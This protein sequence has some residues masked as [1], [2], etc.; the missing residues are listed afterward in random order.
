MNDYSDGLLPQN[1]TH[2]KII[3]I[4]MDAFYAAVEIRDHP[5]LKNKAVVIGQDPRNNNGHGVVAT[6]NYVARQF[7]VHSAMASAKAL[8]LVPQEKLKFLN[9]DFAKYRQVSLAIHQMMAELTDT[10]QSIAL[11]EAYLDVSQNKLG[12]TSS[13]QLAIDL[14]ARIR[15]EV[16]LN[17]SF[18]A[19]YNKFLAKMGSE[20]S[21]PLGRTVILPSEAKSFLARQKIANFHGIGPKTQARLAE[22]GVYTGGDLQK[23][24]VRQLIDQFNRAGYMMAAHANGIDLSRVVPDNERNRK[25]IGIERTYE[26]CV[27][28]EQVALTNIRNYALDLS[29]KLQN[30]EF[31]ANTIVL[32]IRNNDFETVTKRHKLDHATN[33]STEIYEAA[34]AL[35]DPLATQFLNVGI[36]L[37]GVTA[38]DFSEA[39]FENITLD[40]FTD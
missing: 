22:L 23:M 28:D 14:Q 31:F 16:G 37:L 39:D 9:P 13:V 36:R 38:T 8:R 33:A 6:C 15:K 5:E 17:C 40:L 32:K 4:D 20:Y 34:R 21:K 29:E 11:D 2:R 12:A 26:P 27:Y 24:H 35:F 3:H 18:G 30:R 25:S 7:G 10:I 1:D 19:T